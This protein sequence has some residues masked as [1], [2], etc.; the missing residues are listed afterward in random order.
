MCNFRQPLK[1][2]TPIKMRSG[3][4][5]KINELIGCGGL[6]LVYSTIEANGLSTKIIKEF[7]QLRRNK[8]VYML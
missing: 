7:S 3:A 8:W 5:Y 1:A 4:E 2:G 6:S